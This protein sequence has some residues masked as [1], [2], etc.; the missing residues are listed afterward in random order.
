MIGRALFLRPKVDSGD[1]TYGIRRLVSSTN[2]AWE[3]IL[4][5]KG[6]IAAA[7]KDGN[8]VVN[9]FDKI[10]PWSDI[11]SV[12]LAAN[13]TINSHIGDAGYNPESPKG[14]IM[15]YIP[16]FYWNRERK[17]ESGGEYEYIYI[18]EKESD[19]TPRLSKEFYIGRYESCG[20]GEEISSLA[21][22]SGEFV[23]RRIW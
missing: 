4:D 10:Y 7:T 1:K 11:I 9:N 6:K 13:G 14:N 5:N 12:D 23:F 3:R 16:Q 8:S 19:L 22:I 2:S 21:S 17:T 18:S 15:T 20:R